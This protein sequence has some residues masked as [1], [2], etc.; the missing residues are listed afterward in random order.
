GLDELVTVGLIDGHK[1][2]ISGAQADGCS[3]VATAFR[4]GEEHIRPVK[5]QTIAKSLAIGNPADGYY[6]IKAARETGGVIESVSDD[7]ILQGIS[8]LARTEGIFTETAGGVTIATLRKL[9]AA[10][11]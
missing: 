1:T 8:L 10:G 6:A 3:P 11:I 7:E 4:N 5:P 9:A 2:R